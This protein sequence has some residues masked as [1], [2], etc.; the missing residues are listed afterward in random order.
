[1]RKNILLIIILFCGLLSYAQECPKISNPTN[2]SIEVP[3]E[4]SIRWP[5]IDGIFGYLISLGTTP[6]G[7]DILNRRS[8]GQTNSFTPEVGLPDNTLIYVTIEMFLP[9]QQ[10]LI[11]PS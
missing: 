6:G 3:V 1:M 8:A 10:L 5:A 2:G 9:N 11:C 7:T 4:T